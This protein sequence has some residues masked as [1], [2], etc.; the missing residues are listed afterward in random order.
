MAWVAVNWK[1]N[2]EVIFAN[3]PK[4]IKFRGG[5][6]EDWHEEVQVDLYE[7]TEEYGIDLPKGTIKKLIGRNMTFM[8]E[9][10]EI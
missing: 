8:D 7:I 9:P 5:T 2:Q 10:V 6:Y 3:R 4:R 1:N